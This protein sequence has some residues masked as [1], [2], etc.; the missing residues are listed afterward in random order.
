LDGKV[1]KSCVTP[2]SRLEG[3]NIVTLEGL[4]EK[5]VY[6]YA[7]AEAG[8]VQCGF[9]I[10][11]M[12]IAAKALLNVICQRVEDGRRGVSGSAVAGIAGT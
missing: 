3:K 9:C 10:P 8:A 5:E 12:V 6:A 2:L 4:R 1:I 7:F 11:G